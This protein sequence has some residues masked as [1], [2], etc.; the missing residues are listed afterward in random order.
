MEDSWDNGKWEITGGQAIKQSLTKT[1][2]FLCKVNNRTNFDT[3]YKAF[4]N[5]GDGWVNIIKG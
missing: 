1:R 5:V 4:S 2:P 3:S